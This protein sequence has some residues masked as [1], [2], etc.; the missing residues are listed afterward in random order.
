MV[1]DETGRVTL[2]IADFYNGRVRTVGPEGV[3]K[4]VPTDG[5]EFGAPTRVAYGLVR[6]IPRLYV[7]DSY[8]DH[9]V[10]L[11]LPKIAPDL[12]RAKPPLPPVLP[13]KAIG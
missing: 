5:N 8:N 3:I 4:D 2:Y 12:V 7:S 10:A 11:N 1:P 13:R 9:V 6:G